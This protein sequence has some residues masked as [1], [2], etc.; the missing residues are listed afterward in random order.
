MSSSAFLRLAAA[1]TVVLS[2]ARAAVGTTASMATRPA[3][4]AVTATW[5]DPTGWF[6]DSDAV[7]SWL[8]GLHIL[9]ILVWCAGLVYLPALLAAH[10]RT[11]DAIEMRRLRAMTRFTYVAVTSPA[12]IIAIVAGTLLIYP[13]RPV[14]MWLPAKLT[15]VSLL[16]L[17]HVACGVLIGKLHDRPRLLASGTQLSLIAIPSLLVLVILWLVLGK[18]F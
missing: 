5:P 17:F 9:G 4:S 16:M 2:C 14:G 7:S 11:T 8:K 13:A 3:A 6:G 12:A 15:A 10:P 18:P 1:N